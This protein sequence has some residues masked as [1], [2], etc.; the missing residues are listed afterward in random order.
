MTSPV[1]RIYHQ[2]TPLKTP[3][4]W[5]MNTQF[6]PLEPILNPPKSLIDF[7]INPWR[8]GRY[9]AKTFHGVDGLDE[10]SEFWEKPCRKLRWVRMISHVRSR[11]NRHS[12]LRTPPPN[13]ILQICII[14]R[15][16]LD[17]SRVNNMKVFFGWNSLNQ[18]MF[19]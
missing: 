4:A 17:L 10:G 18:F 1:C 8:Y 14:G 13:P 11:R 12:L 3:R 9:L 6:K 19:F 15:L 7:K 16:V 5:L 2:T